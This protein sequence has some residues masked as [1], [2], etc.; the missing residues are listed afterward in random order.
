M[1][2][3]NPAPAAGNDEPLSFDDGVDALTDL[4]P[5]PETDL[6]EEDQGQEEA[7]ETEAEGTRTDP[8]TSQASL[9]PILQTSA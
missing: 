1:S 4:M 2:D 8:V 9:R 7:E 6:K 3:T 5:D